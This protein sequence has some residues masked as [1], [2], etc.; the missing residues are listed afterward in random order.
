[1]DLKRWSSNTE[2]LVDFLKE[3]R[4][5]EQQ[6]LIARAKEKKLQE[7]IKAQKKELEAEGYDTHMIFVMT[8]L[9]VAQQRNKERDRVLPEKLVKK[10]WTDT[11]KNLGAY[12]ALFAGNFVMVDNS[13]FLD[14]KEASH[15]F[16]DIAKSYVNKW[17]NEPIKNP[18]GQK[19]IQ[20]Q[21]KIKQAGI[22][23]ELLKW[24]R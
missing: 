12:K 2:T 24:L 5:K 11:R 7:K 14:A 17:A 21:F 3:E 23:Q 4:D 9:E 20:D 18:I 15:K 19:W 22:K 8:S 10:S 6:R 13:N 16:G 1:M